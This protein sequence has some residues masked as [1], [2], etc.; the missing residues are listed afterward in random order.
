MT[1]LLESLSISPKSMSRYVFALANFSTNFSCSVWTRERSESAFPNRLL[2]RAR[3][4]GSV[5]S[6]VR[7]KFLM[8]LKRSAINLIL[9]QLNVRY[10]KG[11][12]GLWSRRTTT[13]RGR[14]RTYLDKS[15]IPPLGPSP[16]RSS[17]TSIVFLWKNLHR[18]PG[19][20]KQGL[21]QTPLKISPQ[22]LCICGMETGPLGPRP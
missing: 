7:K 6:S 15:T 19:R 3:T 12:K 20:L 11:T 18:G 21:L 1:S 8:R 14:P 16:S 4:T 2:S 9:R 17:E 22:Q 13:V 10:S 5:K